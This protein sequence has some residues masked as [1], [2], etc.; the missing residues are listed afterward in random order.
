[1]VIK[2]CFVQ[3]FALMTGL[4]DQMLSNKPPIYKV[5]AFL[6]CFIVADSY[7]L[8]TGLISKEMIQM[9]NWEGLTNRIKS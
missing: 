7:V 5:H 1:V 2:Y 6:C 9:V 8:S 4:N 3:Y